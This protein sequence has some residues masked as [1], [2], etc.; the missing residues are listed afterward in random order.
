MSKLRPPEMTDPFAIAIALDE[1]ANLEAAAPYWIDDDDAEPGLDFCLTCAE[2]AA[3]DSG[4]IGV[5]VACESKESDGCRH[6]EVCARVLDYL[7]TEYGVL[8]E[9]SHFEENPPTAPLYKETAFHI[10]RLVEGISETLDE[11][12]RAAILRI[13]SAALVLVE[14]TDHA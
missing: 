6:C 4:S 12:A 3:A 14:D 5:V 8:E 2:K 11:K 9:L 13:A 10:A 7:L 1:F